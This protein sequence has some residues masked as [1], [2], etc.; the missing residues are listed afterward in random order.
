MNNHYHNP[1]T[2]NLPH[3]DLHGEI[4]ETVPFK[5]NEF[6][7]DQLKMGNKEVVIIHGRS[8]TVVKPRC[9]ETLKKNKKVSEFHIDS[10]NDGETI[11][12]LK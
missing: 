7:D 12:K 2:Y 11:V 9:I 10:D 3:L 5:V 8:G 1:F 6:I 4:Y